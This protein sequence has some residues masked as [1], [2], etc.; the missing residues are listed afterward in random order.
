LPGGAPLTA[1]G[2]VP[3]PAGSEVWYRVSFPPNYPSPTRLQGAGSPRITLTSGDPTIRMEVRTSCGTASSCGSMTQWVFVDNAGG[4]TNPEDYASRLPLTP[5]PDPAYIRLYRTA[6]ATTCANFVV[7]ATRP[8]CSSLS[9][10]ICDGID[11]DCNG[12]VDEGF[13]RIG[14]SCFTNGQLNPANNCQVCTATAMASGPTTWGNV[15][16]GSVCRPA[17]GGCDLAETCNG[18]GSLCPADGRVGAGVTCRGSV[19]ACDLAETC[20][21]SATACP[22][23]GRVG[24]GVICRSSVG[25]CDLAETCDNS[26]T[27]CPTDN[28]V[29]VGVICR[30]SSGACDLAETCNNS[31][32]ACPADGSRVGAGV[33]CRGSVGACDLGGDLQRCGDG[34]PDGQPRRRWGDLP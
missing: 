18:S 14:G 21:G 1:T 10:E 13:C 34:V 26:A 11:N 27:A 6:G 20:N 23:D 15:A 28:R 24:A 33:T 8:T 7:T 9:M 17:A 19:G 29:G 16:G 22:T 31:A 30:S 2:Y 4:G 5:W 3:A 25:A 12:L 32:T